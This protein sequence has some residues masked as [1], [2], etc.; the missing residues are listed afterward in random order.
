MEYH[1]EKGGNM[2]KFG[3]DISSFQGDFSFKKAKKDDVTFA[4]I[5]AGFTDRRNGFS[6]TVD[7]RFEENYRHA[8]EAKINVGAYWYSRATTYEEG[9]EEAEFLYEHCLKD[10]TFEYPIAMDVEDN[11]YQRKAGRRRVTDAILGFAEYLE[12]KGYYVIIYA[13]LNW[14]FHYM[15][16]R[17]LRAYD[18]WVAYWERFR[19][20][21]LTYGM[22][23]FSG[24][25]ARTIAGVDC[26]RDYSYKDYPKIMKDKGLNGFPKKR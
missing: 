15:E 6:K 23:Q 7:P 16:L 24:G 18:K 21:G 2:K 13:S 8:K 19:P 5:R 22:W 3:I 4:M 1:I 9:R 14:F 26:D 20:T 11:I 25:K 17:R 10:K 12:E